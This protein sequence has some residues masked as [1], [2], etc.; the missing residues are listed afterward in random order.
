MRE[1]W[2]QRKVNYDSE[3]RG[4]SIGKASGLAVAG[5]LRKFGLTARDLDELTPW[6]LCSA[7]LFTSSIFLIHGPILPQ[8]TVSPPVRESRIEIRLTSPAQGNLHTRITYAAQPSS[9]PRGGTPNPQKSNEASATLV[10]EREL[11]AYLLV[12]QKRIETLGNEALRKGIPRGK[13]TV[14]ITLAPSGRVKEL[15]ITG[16]SANSLLDSDIRAI[17]AKASPFPPLPPAWQ[18]PPNDLRIVRTWIFS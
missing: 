4:R 1:L 10:K 5:G 15:V 7:L 12:W 13:V 18:S 2:Q 6:L 14:E 16:Q 11:Q 17:I 3:A 9:S 8:L